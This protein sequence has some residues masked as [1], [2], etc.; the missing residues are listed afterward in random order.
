MTKS[1]RCAFDTTESE[2]ADLVLPPKLLGKL[3]D[4]RQ[5]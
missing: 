2:A 3:A 4:S 1:S 5:L